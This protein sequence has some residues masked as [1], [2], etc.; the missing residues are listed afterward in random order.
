MVMFGLHSLDGM[1]FYVVLMSIFFLSSCLSSLL[2]PTF[3][4]VVLLFSLLACLLTY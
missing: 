3:S 4:L 2:S 1:V